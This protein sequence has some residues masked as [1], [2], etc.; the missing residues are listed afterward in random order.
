MTFWLDQQK[1]EVDPFKYAFSSKN[2]NICCQMQKMPCFSL[3]HSIINKIYYDNNDSI[4]TSL[5]TFEPKK[6]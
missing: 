4:K 6:K 2:K 5:W 1:N 3:L